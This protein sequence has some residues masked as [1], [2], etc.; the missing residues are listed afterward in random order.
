MYTYIYETMRTATHVGLPK[1]M[2]SGRSN[3]CSQ[4]TNRADLGKFFPHRYT[5]DACIKTLDQGAVGEEHGSLRTFGPP[6]HHPQGL[7]VDLT[8]RAQ[9]LAATAARIPELR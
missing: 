4:G 9:K 1:C 6:C 3:I 8:L 2:R 5:E 7:S